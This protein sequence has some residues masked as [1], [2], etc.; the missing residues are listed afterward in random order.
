MS[1]ILFVIFL[2]RISRCSQEV[3]GVTFGDHKISS[4][5]L[6]DD[7]VPSASS[8]NNLQLAV[9]QIAARCEATSLRP[10]LSVRKGWSTNV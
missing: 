1:K 2:D 4:L 6:A 5:L 3:E 7:V 8:T 9:R 10:W